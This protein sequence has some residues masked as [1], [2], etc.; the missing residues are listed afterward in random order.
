MLIVKTIPISTIQDAFD[1]GNTK[2][3]INLVITYWYNLYQQRMTVSSATKQKGA[4]LEEMM[5]EVKGRNPNIG[6]LYVKH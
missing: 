3:N 5:N 4:K 6:Y 1:I 2:S